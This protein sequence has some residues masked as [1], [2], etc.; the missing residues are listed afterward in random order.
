[1]QEVE[2][3]KFALEALAASDSWDAGAG[4]VF[5]FPPLSAHRHPWGPFPTEQVLSGR[6]RELGA[7]AGPTTPSAAGDAGGN[8]GVERGNQGPKP[9]QPYAC[10]GQA[11]CRIQGCRSL[12]VTHRSLSCL[13]FPGR[14]QIP[15]CFL[16]LGD[17]W[18][19]G[20]C[21][22]EEQGCGGIPGCVPLAIMQTE[23]CPEP[24]A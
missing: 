17:A 2:G 19:K 4:R 9:N 15:L 20:P 23:P 22:T 11:G 24:G 10:V 13:A 6:S 21:P 7:S 16:Q 3:E 14:E 8:S 5:T 18:A 12:R 1:M